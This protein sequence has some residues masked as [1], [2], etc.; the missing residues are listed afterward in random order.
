MRI[1]AA[2]YSLRNLQRNN[3]AWKLL[4]AKS[5]PLVLAIIEEHLGKDIP[6]RPAAELQEL[7]E[8]DFAELRMRIPELEIKRSAH[9]YLEKW[10]NDGYLICRA[11]DRVRQ[12]TY[13]LSSG[14]IQ[15]I[16]FVNSLERPHHSATRSRLSLILEQVADLSLAVDDDIERKRE[17][18]LAQRAQI[19]AQLEALS[20]GETQ[21][22][23]PAQALEQAQEIIAL[24][25]EVPRDFTNVAAEFESISKELF[26]SLILEDDE[27]KDVLENVFAGVDQIGQSSPGQT[28]KG[29][30]ELLRNVEATERFQ[31]DI[32]VILDAG[33]ASTIDKEDRLFLR[34][35]IRDTLAR[36]RDVNETL[37]GLARGLRR[38]VQ[39]QSFEHERRIKRSIDQALAYAN[40]LTDY[41]PT[42]YVMDAA[43][44]LT[45]TPIAPISRLRLFDPSER[46]AEPI[47]LIEEDS[48]EALSL[49]ELREL[50]REVEIDFKE[51]AENVNAALDEAS[52]AF[53]PGNAEG[54]VSVSVGDVLK[55]FPSTQ[56]LA[57]VVGLITLALEQGDLQ[58]TDAIERVTWESIGGKKHA[59]SIEK[60]LFVK[61]IAL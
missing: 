30:Y 15:A 58:S 34:H 10:R 16:A 40:E 49:E 24:S 54:A 33:F 57:S 61:E 45:S 19:D 55:R 14:A 18:L 21:I 39:S 59:A 22:K 44:E 43:L 48:K 42:S 41:V 52:S 1:A 20:E 12:E 36:S 26:R 23:D 38:F 51:L 3:V 53:A 27:S 13:E 50:V 29:F 5:A 7:V 32:D 2:V 56:G 17:A 31:D 46:T 25:R 35:F 9:A 28:F 8:A 47:A 4:R 60:M 11:S 6:R 37:T